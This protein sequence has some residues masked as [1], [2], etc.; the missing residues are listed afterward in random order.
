MTRRAFTLVEVL[1]VVAIIG[2]LIALLL[3]AVQ[4][5]RESARR[6][7]CLNNLKQIGIGLHNHAAANGSLPAGLIS[8]AYPAVPTHP[9]TFYRWSA[10]AQLLPYLE[11]ENLR[12]MLDLSLPL[13]MPDPG[14][15]ISAPNKAAVSQLVPDFLCP[16][17]SGEAVNAQFGPTN[18][19][20]CAGSG[21]GGGTPFNTDGV[22]YVNSATRFGDITDGASNTVAFSESL[23]GIDT[24]RDNTGAFT[25][26]SP[27]RSYKFLL[28]FSAPFDLTDASC[29]GSQSFNSAVAT[30]NDPRG[31]AWCSG[32]YRAALYNHYYAPNSSSYDCVTSVTSDPTP[33]PAKPFLYAAYGWRA[34]RSLHPGGVNTLYAD[35]SGHLV[36]DN[37]DL[38]VWQGLSTRNT[39]DSADNSQ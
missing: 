26:Y 15:P 20:A 24:P 12:G 36:R 10:L 28:R 14:Y 21:T 35:G 39:S 11:K 22:F 30:G 37:I 38:K 1:V 29:N 7:Q 16:C 18:Y 9:Y 25:G 34:A 32:E 17:D 23:V 5:A 6:M 19:V 27:Q 3:P 13:Y 33:P 31:F 8:Q 4:A 2:L